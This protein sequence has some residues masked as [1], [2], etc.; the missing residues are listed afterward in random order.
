MAYVL[1]YHYNTSSAIS[2]KAKEYWDEFT[3]GKDEGPA[4]FSAE[5]RRGLLDHVHGH[6]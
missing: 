2:L 1:V 4:A 3:P 6:L 5:E